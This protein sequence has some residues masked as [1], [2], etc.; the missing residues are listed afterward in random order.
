MNY[1]ETELK[2]LLKNDDTIFGFIKASALDGMWY[3]DLEKPENEW[4]DNRFWTTLGYEP[5]SFPKQ[6]LIWKN[7]IFKEDLD[8]IDKS[9]HRHLDDSNSPYDQIVRFLHKDGHTVW[10]RCWGKVIR[11]ESGKPIRMFGA[12][13]DLTELK[14]KEQILEHCNTVASIGH[15]Q[16]NLETLKLNLGKVAKKILQ[17]EPDLSPGLKTCLDKLENRN[18]RL[19]IINSSK[20]ALKENVSFELELPILYQDGSTHWIKLIGIPQ[21]G[22][23]KILGFYGTIQDIN[24]Q[25]IQ[26]LKLTKEREKLNNVIKGTNVGTWEWNVQ[27][28]EAI[29]NKRSAEII[30]YTLEELAPISIKTLESFIHPDDFKK[31][32]KK[33]KKYFSGKR[34]FYKCEYRVRHKDGHWLW[35]LD[36]GKAFSWTADDRP[37][38]MFGTHQ[39]ITSSKQLTENQGL[40][41]KHAPSA[42]AMVDLDFKYIGTSQKWL[43]S[44]HIEKDDMNHLSLLDTF[45]ETKEKLKEIR[46]YCTKG[47]NH[48][49][50]AYKISKEGKVQWLR[51]EASPWINDHGKVGGFIMS[52]EDITQQKINEEKLKISELSFLRNFSNAAIGMALVSLEGYWLKVNKKLCQMIGYTTEELL[53]L[54]FAE[55]TH[56]D[57]LETDLA[58]CEELLAGK[59]ENYQM[60]KRYYHKN[61]DIVNIILAV[62]LLRGINNKPMYFISQ[63]I[64]ITELKQAQQK[65]QSLLNTTQE[66]NSRLQNFAHIVSHNLKSHSG[67][68]DFMI[69]IVLDEKPDL[70]D[71]PTIAHLKQAS[72]NLSETI[73]HLNEVALINTSVKENLKCISVHEA[74]HKGIENVSALAQSAQV[75][76]INKIEAGHEILGLP[77]Y[78]DSIILNFLTNGIR[79]RSNGKADK[80]EISSQE[81]GNYIVIKFEDNGL[82][83]DLQRNGKELFGMYKTFHR[84]PESRGIG[85]FITKSQVDALGGK[86]EV[87]SE[88]NKG[89]MFKVYFQKCK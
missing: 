41:I 34:D 19:L 35:I 66:Q 3:W 70:K 43:Q 12:H 53:K 79:Y 48:S 16:L 37:L 23:D 64:D 17:I 33:L 11:D 86:I 73:Y 71:L 78:L 56:P 9:L 81:Q 18:D 4:M 83:M 72:K 80:L 50:E 5:D 6:A 89:T 1:L 87:T 20:E 57:D 24:E 62:S 30:G 42:L 58:F 51:W 59:R 85:L 39:D 36:K 74:I 60:E 13:I 49:E 32:Q 8:Q 69:D 75:N 26:N 46:E 10:L 68:I 25:K 44:F 84:H 88:V 38:Q 2:D 29:C 55:I 27:T 63:I 61:G 65:I 67:N 21:T 45:P 31:Q 47:L 15:W 14:T 82:G 54:T 22:N 76:I 7:F 40:F 77:A 28:G 52:A